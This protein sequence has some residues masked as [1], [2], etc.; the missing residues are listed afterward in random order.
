MAARRE[1]R[2]RL[3][4]AKWDWLSQKSRQMGRRSPNKVIE[5]SINQG[6]FEDM[7]LKGKF[8]NNNSKQLKSAFNAV[9]DKRR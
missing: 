1:I 9:N 6:L 4:K 7:L 3:N 8:G 2:L 5:A